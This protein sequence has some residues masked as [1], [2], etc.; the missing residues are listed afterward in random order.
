MHPKF[1]P[2]GFSPGLIFMTNPQT[3]SVYQLSASVPTVCR[4]TGTFIDE[5]M[6]MFVRDAVVGRLTLVDL[7]IKP[8][9]KTSIWFV[10][11]LSSLFHN[12]SLNMPTTEGLS[13]V[14]LFGDFSSIDLFFCSFATLNQT[15]QEA[16]PK[17]HTMV[18]RILAVTDRYLVC[19][20]AET[21]EVR[22]YLGFYYD[23]VL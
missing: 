12:Q 5:D 13:C 15:E 2:W 10:L 11:C 8:L 3:H 21:R 20:D 17:T 6:I 14:N 18:Y 7:L 23:C 22:L 1:Y 16:C 4:F 9:D 19:L